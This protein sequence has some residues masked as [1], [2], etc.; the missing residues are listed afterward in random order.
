[1]TY[2][3][4]DENTHNTNNI[5]ENARKKLKNRIRIFPFKNKCH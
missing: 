2:I 4:L 5:E 3:E 1:M